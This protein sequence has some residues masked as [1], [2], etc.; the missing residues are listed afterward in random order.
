MKKAPKEIIK[1]TKNHRKKVQE[2]FSFPE[3]KQE[4]K[5]YLSSMGIYEERGSNAYMTRVRNPAGV[6]SIEELKL[7][8]KLADLYAQNEIHFT[9]RQDIQFHRVKLEDTPDLVEKL[10]EANLYTRGSGG[11]GVRNIACSSLA[12]IAPD[13]IFDVTP[14]ALQTMDYL[15]TDSDSFLL[16]RKFKIAFS[17]SRQDTAYATISDLGFIAKIQDGQRG[18]EVYGGGGL[19]KNPSIG[20]KLADFISVDEV[21]YYVFAM[22]DFFFREGDRENRNKARIRYILFRLGEEEFTNRFFQYLE[23]AKKKYGFVP[24]EIT[25]EKECGYL[26]IHPEIGFISTQNLNKIISF[27]EN[28]DYKTRIRLASTQ[29][30]YVRNLRPEDKK[31]LI[32]ITAGFSQEDYPVSCVGASV[33]K[34]GLCNSQKLA[35]RIKTKFKDKKLPKIHIS[36]C[37]NSCGQHQIAEIGLSGKLVKTDKGLEEYFTVFSGGKTETGKTRFGKQIAELPAE[38]I[39]GFLYEVLKNDL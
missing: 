24:V 1:Y 8:S 19:G 5:K 4:K 15:L 26:F 12:G 29:G 13:E 20:I 10:M 14:Y 37:H 35:R 22:K 28:L 32:K 30:F 18:F 11:N 9:T 21:F 25:R 39:P 34:I 3:E 16:P 6:V 2:I 31:E 17:N 23:N 7:I 27:L 36:G 33:C 38:E